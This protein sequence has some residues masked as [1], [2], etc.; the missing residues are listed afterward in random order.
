[1]F[2]LIQ[3]MALQTGLLKGVVGAKKICQYSQ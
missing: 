3:E 1:M 2:H